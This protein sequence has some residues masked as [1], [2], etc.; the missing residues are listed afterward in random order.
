MLVLTRKLQEKIRIG[1][2]VTITVLR[3][4]GKAVRLGIEA[5]A[6]VSVIRGELVHR[7][8]SEE[9]EKLASG[10]AIELTTSELVAGA[11]VGPTASFSDRTEP[12]WARDTHPHLSARRAASDVAPSEVRFNRISRDKAAQ[13]LAGTAASGGGPLRT[14]LDQRAKAV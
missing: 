5:P 14:M 11:S 4:K 6:N 9:S 10:E 1:D 13:F 8:S 3:M 12:A 7:L 2:Q